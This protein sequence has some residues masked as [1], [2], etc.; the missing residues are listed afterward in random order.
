MNHGNSHAFHGFH[1]GF[2]EQKRPESLNIL[3][4]L[5]LPGCGSQPCAVPASLRHPARPARGASQTYL[6]KPRLDVLAQTQQG[7]Q[8]AI[9]ALTSKDI[10]LISVDGNL[11]PLDTGR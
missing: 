2:F 9:L 6:G 10:V 11:A 3:G 8:F 1:I 7:Q 4:S 5:Q